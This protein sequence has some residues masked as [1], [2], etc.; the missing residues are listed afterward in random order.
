MFISVSSIHTNAAAS[1]WIDCINLE[2]SYAGDSAQSKYDDEVFVK[3]KIVVFRQHFSG[4]NSTSFLQDLEADELCDEDE[5]K[6]I[7]RTFSQDDCLHAA[8]AHCR[9][10]LRGSSRLVRARYNFQQ[11]LINTREALEMQ[12]PS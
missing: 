9:P 5:Y 4:S 1:E 11:G 8:G 12:G 6:Q 2:M 7:S 3:H 10:P